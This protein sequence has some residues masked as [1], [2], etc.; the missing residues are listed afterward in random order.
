MKKER[1]CWR[2]ARGTHKSSSVALRDLAYLLGW[3]ESVGT[4]LLSSK[5]EVGP[6]ATQHEQRDWAIDDGRAFVV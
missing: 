5:E 2:G 3:G 4:L 6:E 1:S